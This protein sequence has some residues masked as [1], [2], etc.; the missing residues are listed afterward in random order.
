[1]GKHTDAVKS[2]DEFRAPWETADGSEAEIDKPKLKRYIY[3]LVTDKAKAQDARDEGAEALTQAQADLETAKQEAANANG[4][5]AQKKIDAL[6]AKVD[7]L[8][9][10]ADARKAADEHEALRKDVIG[11]LDPKYAKYVVGEDREALEKSLEEVKADFNITDGDGDDDDDD[12]EPKVRTTPR[13]KQVRNPA[14]P[15]AGKGADQ[16]Y[17]FDKIADG[18]VG[19]GPFG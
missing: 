12:D 19:G 17:D 9:G 5:E 10:E 18:I 14:D 8:Q 1:M 15:Q 4:P 2:F 7:K 11:D 13:T 6:Q 3:G 16:E